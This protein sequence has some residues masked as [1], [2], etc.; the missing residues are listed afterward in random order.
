MSLV[1][2]DAQPSDAP[3]VS[4]LILLSGPSFLT[5]LLGPQ[6][7]DIV[8]TL[9]PRKHNLFSHEFTRVAL[10]GE[11]TAGMLVGCT[12]RQ[13][14]KVALHTGRLLLQRSRS[15]LLTTLRNL[16]RAEML[17]TP[18]GKADFYITSVAV[19]PQVRGR[20]VGTMLLLDAQSR[21][22]AAKCRRLVLDVEAENRPALSLYRKLGFV[23]SRH[24]SARIGGTEFTF[25]SMMRQIGC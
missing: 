19:Y 17:L 18:P 23:E 22:R 14:N 6:A 11:K 21:A 3:D 10:V 20:G 15:R 2:R 5:A 9:V 16:V 4:R 7:V 25:V 12:G 13:R 1:I 24:A 8:E